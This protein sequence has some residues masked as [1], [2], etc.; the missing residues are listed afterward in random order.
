MKVIDVIDN[1]MI[2]NDDNIYVKYQ[3]LILIVQLF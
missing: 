3:H 2:V 1:Y